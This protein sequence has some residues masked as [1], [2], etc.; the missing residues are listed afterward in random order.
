MSMSL[1]RPPGVAHGTFD[2]DIFHAVVP[3]DES[4][5]ESDNY[6]GPSAAQLSR[7]SYQLDQI[8][9]HF[10]NV[11]QSKQSV[12]SRLEG[13]AQ[14]DKRLVAWKDSLPSTY[15]PDS[16]ILVTPER[17]THVLL[18]HLDYSN[19]LRAMHLAAITMRPALVNTA[20]QLPRRLQASEILCVEAARSFIKRLNR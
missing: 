13:I 12:V 16:V 3:F 6:F 20:E 9:N 7:W 14:A 11:L 2:K 19:L 8:V 15:R 10:C 1:G 5:R 4:S 18:L 17:F